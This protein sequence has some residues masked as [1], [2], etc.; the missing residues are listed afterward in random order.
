MN[1]TNPAP[2][3]FQDFLE[4]RVGADNLV[5]SRALTFGGAGAT[6]ALIL[7]IAQMGV[8][9]SSLAWSLGLAAAALPLW[10]SVAL[11]YD[12][13]L[14]LKLD[15]ADLYRLKWLRRIQSTAIFVSSWLTFGSIATLLY[16]LA[17]TTAWI[18]VFTC[19]VGVCLVGA[20]SLAAAFR[21]QHHM[22]SV[23]PNGQGGHEG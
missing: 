18:F 19:V 5:N 22:K 15:W 17:P 3:Q 13:W 20:A 7:L 12:A 6:L 11:T 4:R 21:L 14:S 8:G 9:K 1:S 23:Q 16:S 10:V 2:A